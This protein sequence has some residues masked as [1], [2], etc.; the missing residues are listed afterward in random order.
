MFSQAMLRN[1]LK[2]LNIW[3]IFEDEWKPDEEQRC[4]SNEQLDD[5]KDAPVVRC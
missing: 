5:R 2:H 3:R 1:H 4:E